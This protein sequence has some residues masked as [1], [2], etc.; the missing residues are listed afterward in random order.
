ML[1]R[2]ALWTGTEATEL[3]LARQYLFDNSF[4][5]PGGLPANEVACGQKIGIELVLL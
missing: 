2:N 1:D 5:R 4:A 3:R